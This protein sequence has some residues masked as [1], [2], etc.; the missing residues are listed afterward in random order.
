MIGVGPAST[1]DSK[2]PASC[3]ETCDPLHQS[4]FALTRSVSN[5]PSSSETAGFFQV[6]ARLPPATVTGAG[7]SL[8]RQ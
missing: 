8:V 1:P 6:A 7:S 3:P 4:V 5:F 2:S